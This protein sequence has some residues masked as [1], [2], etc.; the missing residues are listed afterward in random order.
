MVGS[1]DGAEV[2]AGDDAALLLQGLY[3]S[4]TASDGA[5]FDAASLDLGSAVSNVTT[6]LEEELLSLGE[7]FLK[8]LAGVGQSHARGNSE[9]QDLEA[10]DE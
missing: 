3:R 8:F 5:V 7:L 4:G 9:E 2:A 10:H 6:R 1:Q